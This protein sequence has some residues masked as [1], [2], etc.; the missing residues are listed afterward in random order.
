[1]DLLNPEPGHYAAEVSVFSGPDVN[2]WDLWTTNVLSGGAP[3]TLDPSM[4][5]VTSGTP[6]SYTASWSGLQPDS[7][8]LGYVEY[9]TSG[10]RTF[11]GVT[12][13]AATDPGTPVNTAPPAI[14]G[15]PAIGAKLTAE[16]GTWTGE[17]LSYAYQWQR[18][19]ADIAKATSAAYTVTKK[20]AGHALTVVVTATSSTGATASATSAP[21]TVPVPST[22]TLKLS[23]TVVFGQPVTATVKVKAGGAAAAGSVQLTID[24]K[25]VGTPVALAADGTAHIALPKLHRGYHTVKAVYA[26]TEG[27]APSSSSGAPLFVLW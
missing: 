2:Q 18:D 21:V 11:V 3:L 1:V 19:G 12:T 23:R 25:S 4:L 14:T 17:G 16:P 15:D 26:G 5:P 13:G 27:V 9:G 7:T 8:Y 10:T 20:D 6:T 24:G 22:T